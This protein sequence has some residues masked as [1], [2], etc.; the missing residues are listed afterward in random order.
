MKYSE[1]Q[2][3]EHIL[4]ETKRENNVFINRL[5]KLSKEEKASELMNQRLGLGEYAVGGTKAIRYYDP[6]QY[7]REKQIRAKVSRE[8]GNDVNQIATD[9]Y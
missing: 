3:R 4:Q 7:A 2:I 5:H 6:Q 8:E 1:E 9:D